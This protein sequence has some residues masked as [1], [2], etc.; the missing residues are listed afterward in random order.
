MHL[1]FLEDENVVFRVH[2]MTKVVLQDII[3][4]PET[5][6]LASKFVMTV[7]NHDE[8]RSSAID[9]TLH[10]LKDPKTNE[11]VS[12]LAASTLKDLINKEEIRTILLEYIKMLILDPKTQQACGTM[13]K[14]LL[15]DPELKSFMAESFGGLVASAVVTNK[16]V[17]LGKNVT[18]Q[19]VSDEAIQRHTSDALWKVVKESITPGWF[20]GKKENAPVE[21]SELEN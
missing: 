21:N 15:E 2:E 6:K 3:N 20:G 13:V 5:T 11:K 7:L 17:E 8:V 18:Q 10:V 9:L 14:T 19:V 4:D 12:E 16:A 1:I